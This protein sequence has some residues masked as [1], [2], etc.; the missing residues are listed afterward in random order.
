MHR[1]KLVDGPLFARAIDALA[2]LARELPVIFPLHPRSRA[3]LPAGAGAPG[4]RL[5]DPVGYVDFLALQT[6]AAAV[7][8][9]SGGVQEETTALGVPCFTLRDTTERPVTVR[10]GTNTVLGLAPE[11]IAE[12]PSALAA[13]RSAAGRPE[14][15]DGRAAERIAEH[16]AGWLARRRVP[17]YA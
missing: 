14:R 1:P 15:W 11:R 10:A 17:A 6:A 12:I 4:L 13:T 2:R 16:L 8:T 7:V 5:V 3:R 9:D